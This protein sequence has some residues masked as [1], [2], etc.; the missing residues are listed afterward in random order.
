MNDGKLIDGHWSVGCWMI[1]CP[2]Q[3][4]LP[5]QKS[6]AG[7]VKALAQRSDDWHRV[8]PWSGFGKITTLNVNARITIAFGLVNG[9]RLIS[10][11]CVGNCIS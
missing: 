3:Y 1:S 8:P 9:V 7:H 6:G 11:S 10:I 4:K 2:G 5:A